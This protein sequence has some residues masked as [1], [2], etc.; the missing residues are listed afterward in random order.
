ME[1]NHGDEFQY[2]GPESKGCS[3][4]SGIN[5]YYSQA[6]YINATPICMFMVNAFHL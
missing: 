3:Y 6:K 4:R 5:K 1:D 2:Q